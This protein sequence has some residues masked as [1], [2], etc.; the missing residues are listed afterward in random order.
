MGVVLLLLVG[1]AVLTFIAIDLLKEIHHLEEALNSQGKM[2]AEGEGMLVKLAEELAKTVFIAI[3]VGVGVEVYL[4]WLEHGEAK[5]EAERG[6]LKSSDIKTLYTARGDAKESFKKLVEDPK[7]NI[8]H[9]AGISLRDFLRSDGKMR[10][11]WEAICRRLLEEENENLDPSAR[12]RVRLLLLDPRSHEGRFRYKIE[13]PIVGDADKPYDIEQ[14]LTEIDRAKRFIFRGTP[15]SFLQERLYGHCPFSFVFETESTIF[16][17]QYYYREDEAEADISAP[18]IEYEAR[19]KRARLFKRSL[20]IIWEK[21]RRN[22]ITVGTALPVE[23]ASIT[24]IFRADQRGELT[25]RQVKAIEAV[26]EGNID[27][28]AISGG[29]YFDTKNARMRAA[30]RDATN[31]QDTSRLVNVRATLLN[32]V[33]QQAIFRA[34]ADDRPI[35]SIRNALCDWDWE[36]HRRSRLFRDITQIT[37]RVKTLVDA[38]YRVEL[39]L[40]SSAVACALMLTPE[41]AF[42]E[43]Y[44]YG[45]TKKLQEQDVLIGEYPVIEYKLLGPD[46]NVNS[47]K[48][49]EVEK[50]IILSTFQIVWD[51]YS[52][53]YEDYIA[54]GD[55]ESKEHAE[56]F[57]RNLAVL[58]EELNCV[59]PTSD[60]PPSPPS[61]GQDGYPD[62]AGVAGTTQ[63][64]ALRS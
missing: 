37:E 45:R 64:Q 43:Q 18:L 47:E 8:V 46:K 57:K 56:E 41:S 38:G 5:Q 61:A 29:H 40:Y 12:L 49:D 7:I 36:K 58:Q 13:E 16:V 6:T 59:V 30:L 52:I 10:Q 25:R 42:V 4:K 1:L 9:I 22:R 63:E 24:N 23:R 55:H 19:S 39:R 50:E 14:S 32:P 20:E 60:T 31:P 11:V 27:I 44:I 62:K 17:E 35:S 26:I 53:P 51:C 21:A 34:V 3:G 33:S 48:D 54:R 28:L 15:Q 2:S